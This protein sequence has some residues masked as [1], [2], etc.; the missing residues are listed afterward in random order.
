[1][2]TST[3]ILT[4][5]AAALALGTAGAVFAHQGEGPGSR[6]GMHGEGHGR[7]HGGDRS[8]QQAERL[9]ALKTELKITAAQEPAWQQYETVLRQQAEARKAMHDKMQAQRQ[10]TP[11]DPKAAAGTDRA[12]LRESMR[13]Q[14]EAHLAARDQARQAL[15][16]V[17]TP[18]QKTLLADQRLG[19]GRGHGQGAGHRG[20]MHRHSS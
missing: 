17:L 8:A 10:A 3:T 5:L 20:P 13:Q 6:M 9:A 16:A 1:M 15:L 7:M 2:K 11:Q 12:A 18:E 14:H 4:A 19:S